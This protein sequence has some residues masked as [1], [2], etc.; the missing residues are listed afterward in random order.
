[1][2]ITRKYGLP[3]LKDLWER[4]EKFIY[5]TDKYIVKKTI[6]TLFIVK[7]EDILP[8]FEKLAW[9]KEAGEPSPEPDPDEPEV[10]HILLSPNLHRDGEYTGSLTAYQYFYDTYE[11]EGEQVAYED[12]LTAHVPA[13]LTEIPNPE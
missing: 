2:I 3:F 10:D 1:M 11:E 12:C 4:G 8:L 5:F 6:I 9:A 7:I 13:I